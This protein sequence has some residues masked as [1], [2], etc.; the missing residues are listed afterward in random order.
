M[1]Q[2]KNPLVV[3]LN[4]L[5]TL[6]VQGGL[7]PDVKSHLSEATTLLLAHASKAQD[8]AAPNPKDGRPL[9]ESEGARTRREAG[10]DPEKGP[11]TASD[12]KDETEDAGTK[13]PLGIKKWASS[14]S[15]DDDE[16]EAKKKV[17]TRGQPQNARGRVRR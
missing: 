3:A 7:P 8:A 11:P 13:S 6:L 16:L 5:T 17:V 12:E 1:E 10:L 2:P 15:D 4:A 14:K 9:G